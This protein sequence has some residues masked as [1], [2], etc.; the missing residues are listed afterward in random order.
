M[1]ALVYTDRQKLEFL[2]VTEPELPE[3]DD[4][5][6]EL[7]VDDMPNWFKK[8][9]NQILEFLKGLVGKE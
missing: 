6:S 5:I 7:P 2:D 1:K 9:L 8:F 4:P 3:T